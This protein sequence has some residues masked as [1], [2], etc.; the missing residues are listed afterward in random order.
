[1]PEQTF[2][3]KNYDENAKKPHQDPRG[4][5]RNPADLTSAAAGIVGPL[6]SSSFSL[7]NVERALSEMEV[8]ASLNSSV[9]GDA[10]RRVPGR[11]PARPMPSML[12]AG[13]TSPTTLGRP[14]PS[15]TG[16][17]GSSPT[18]GQ[19]QHE[20]LQNFFQS[21]LTPKDRAGPAA[22]AASNKQPIARK[23]NGDTGGP[24]DGT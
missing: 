22:T 7:P 6:S 23:P 20:V 19:T 4:A 10:T 17:P 8:G 14:Q 16:L 11:P 2:L 1:L 18:S 12:S 24:E 21:L 9:S 15:P 3:A 5:F 13:A